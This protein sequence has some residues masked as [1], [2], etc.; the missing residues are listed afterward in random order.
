[1]DLKCTTCHAVPSE[2]E[3]PA[4]VSANPGPPIDA[5]VAG[6]DTSCVATAIVSPSHEL[7]VER[8]WRSGPVPSA[9]T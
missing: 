9:S 3:F 5:R 2:S 1:M 7:E 4:P 8:M 6:L